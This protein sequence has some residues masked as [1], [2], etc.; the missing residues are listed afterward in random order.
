MIHFNYLENR[1]S[2][3]EKIKCEMDLNS[4][5]K[6]SEYTLEECVEDWWDLN[7]DKLKKKYGV[8]WRD[9]FED[10]VHGKDITLIHIVGN[11]LHTRKYDWEASEIRRRIDDIEVSLAN[12]A[13]E[14]LCKDDK[15]YNTRFDD[16]DPDDIS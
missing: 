10:I 4:K 13:Y 15:W 16:F 9:R 1:V 11:A 7:K 6:P 5:L 2:K 14:E 3:L 8:S 12:F